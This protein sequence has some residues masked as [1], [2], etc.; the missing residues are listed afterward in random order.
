MT[1]SKSNDYLVFLTELKTKI[2]SSRIVA[3]KTVNKELIL[4]YWH[5]GKEFTERQEKLGWGKSVVEML[6]KDLK[7]EFTNTDVF[8]TRNL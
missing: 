2:Y 7:K 1:F 8:S 6:S 5:I 3:S 4:L